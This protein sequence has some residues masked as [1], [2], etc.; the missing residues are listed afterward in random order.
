MSYTEPNVYVSVTLPKVTPIV[1]T[2]LLRPLVVG[3][4]YFVRNKAFVANVATTAA[5]TFAYPD[6]P[7]STN[8]ASTKLRVDNAS[9]GY[10]PRYHVLDATG[11]EVEVTSHVT[12]GVSTFTF[13]TALPVAGALYVSFRALSDAYTGTSLDMLNASNYADLRTIFG[14]EGLSLANPLGFAM[15][16]LMDNSGLAVSGIAVGAPAATYT[17][18][19]ADEISAYRD[20]EDFAR[21]NDVYG[22]VALSGNPLV[23]QVWRNHVNYMKTDGLSERIQVAAPDLDQPVPVR[24]GDTFLV[25][26]PIT[27]GAG[28]PGLTVLNGGIDP[29]VTP[30]A[31]GSAVQLGGYAV[32]RIGSGLGSAVG[33]YVI[34]GFDPANDTQALVV[35]GKTYSIAYS[36]AT[37]GTLYADLGESV[38]QPQTRRVK[39]GD[40]FRT[41]GTFNAVVAAAGVPGRSSVLA[42][43][44][45]AAEP[46]ITSDDFVVTR[47]PSGR[48]DEVATYVQFSRGY[49]DGRLVPCMPSWLST[50]VAG[51]VIDVPSYFGAVQ[52]LGELC[53]VG[54]KPAGESP[55]VNPF[56]NLSNPIAHTFK[57]VRYF[58]RAELNTIAEAGWTIFVNDSP[59]RPVRTQHTLTSDMSSVES[60]EAV[61]QVER[62]LLAR[63]FRANFADKIRRY[64]INKQT[65]AALQLEAEAVAASLH[66]PGRRTYCFERVTLRSV[67]QHPTKLDRVVIEVSAKQLYPLNESEVNITIV[68]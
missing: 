51:Q 47:V 45:A 28:T 64:R 27:A 66:T 25:G 43:T 57:S 62:D 10:T 12:S 48:T 6:L 20:A 50:T 54:R 40:A 56:T 63:I 67:V 39:V 14:E 16:T 61:L 29:A 49:A 31:V 11:T 19:I 7:D 17:G 15:L 41:S 26:Y 46:F 23:T 60:G 1:N 52:L 34:F 68:V 4:H 2:P 8:V 13:A 33:T 24:G 18:A 9:A 22:I 35:D 5:Q 55:G 59:G 44:V 37:G 53:Q 21:V 42:L 3:P 32:V 38:I 36:R 58:T 65:I 30:S